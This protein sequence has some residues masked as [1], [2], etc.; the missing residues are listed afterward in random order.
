M[1]RSSSIVALA[2]A[3]ALSAF[4][5]GA[6][7]ATL[8]L[9][10][11]GSTGTITYTG[12][13]S[14]LT[15]S[16]TTLSGSSFFLGS[17]GTWSLSPF[18]PMTSGP[19]NNQGQFTFTS[20]NTDTLTVNLGAAGSLTGAVTWTTITDG[21][22]TPRFNGSFIITSISGSLLSNF[23]PVGS[24]GFIDFNSNVSVLLSL[25]QNTHDTITSTGISS[26]ELVPTP[27][28]GALPLFAGGLAGLWALGRK[29]RKQ[30]LESAVA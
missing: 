24:L 8:D 4:T 23:G 9:L 7:A 12:T 5:S 21:T 3:A 11:S 13:G 2:L 20:G 22:L 17:L 18:G 6:N 1:V 30:K 29:R 28:P 27:L 26:G 15:V 19:E 10:G 14:G 25:L 16:S